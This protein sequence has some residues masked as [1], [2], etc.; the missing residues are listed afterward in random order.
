MSDLPRITVVTNLLSPPYDEGMRIWMRSLLD[1]F[2]RS[3]RV[4]TRV[5]NLPVGSSSLGSRLDLLSAFRSADRE[6]PAD[7][8]FY[9]PLASMTF[10]SFLFARL[11][12]SVSSGSPFVCA[13]S[14][15]H[16]NLSGLQESLIRSFLKPDLVC[17]HS[18]ATA[19]ALRR[20]GVA[21]HELLP[22]VDS[23]RF[24]PVDADERRRLRMKYSLPESAFIVLHVGHATQRRNLHLLSALAP[25]RDILPVFVVSSRSESAGRMAELASSGVRIISGYQDAIDE[26]YKLSDL[27][28]FPVEME[29]G[30]I[31]LPLSVLEARSCGLPVLSSRFPAIVNALGNERGVYFFTGEA[32]LHERLVLLKKQS[33]ESAAVT[34]TSYQ[35]L[36]EDLLSQ[37]ST[38]GWLEPPS[39]RRG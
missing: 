18:P 39:K 21:V 22:A 17:T 16:R 5:V 14:L 2:Q 28:F 1:A 20:L 11:L 29:N 6:H 30:A 33:G 4:E 9:V 12:M 26:L 36:A 24:H 10:N 38:R 15:Q 3:E 34:S 7:I 25:D 37:F 32:E 19:A 13:V 35:A 31:D 23:S 8:V 27:Y